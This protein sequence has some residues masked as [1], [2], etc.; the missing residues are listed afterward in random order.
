[1]IDSGQM[2]SIIEALELGLAAQEGDV[3]KTKK[4][5]KEAT[6][7]QNGFVKTGKRHKRG[8]LTVEID[9]DDVISIHQTD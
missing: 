3:N 9:N 4:Q 1:M 2:L 5:K 8:N 7:Q 6:L